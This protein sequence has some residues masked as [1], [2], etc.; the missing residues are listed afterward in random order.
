MS[1][2]P[3][4]EAAVAVE[5]AVIYGSIDKPKA[6]E[7]V[8]KV[9]YRD[10]VS[11]T[12]CDN[13]IHV[14]KSKKG[15][16]VMDFHEMLAPP[17]AWTDYRV[18][19]AHTT[20][21][22]PAN[23]SLEQGAAVPL[24]ALTA[25]VGVY[26]RLQLPEPR[27]PAKKPIP[28]VIYGTASAVGAYKLQVAIKR[29]IHPLICVA[30][31]SQDYVKS[32]IDPATATQSWITVGQRGRCQGYSGK[33]LEGAKL[34]HALGAVSEK[35]SYQNL[36]KILEKEARMALVRPRIDATEIPD[37]I[38]PS[39]TGC[40][41]GLFKPQPTRMVTRGLDGVQHALEKLK[42]GRVNG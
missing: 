32:F 5:A 1:F 21:H 42:A 35:G 16:R 23:T 12:I 9:E 10:D 27:C 37:Y 40:R 33:A 41:Q 20:A 22:L 8:T 15:N 34:F 14:P 3:G 4:T 11:G 18:V 38:E 24:A 26:S 2:S 6:D 30:G 7:V 13:G 19:P 31:N 29:N 25:A 17:G 28:L 36:S 39:Y